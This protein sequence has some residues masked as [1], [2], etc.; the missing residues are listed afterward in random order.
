[1][2]PCFFYL[3]LLYSP[4]STIVAQCTTEEVSL[5]IEF[6]TAEFGSETNWELT[7]N[8]TGEIYATSGFYGDFQTYATSVCVPTG[9]NL[10]FKVSCCIN[11]EGYYSLSIGDFVL[12]ED[13]TYQSNHLFAF[14]ALAPTGL[15]A[16]IKQIDLAKEVLTKPQQIS[17]TLQNIGLENITSFEISWQIEEGNISTY[18]VDSVNIATFE[19]YMFKH[20]NF[21]LPAKGKHFLKVWISQLN[22]TDLSITEMVLWEQVIQASKSL[23]NRTVLV[24]A[25]TNAS[26]SICALAET[27][28]A[29]TALSALPKIA[30]IFYHVPYPGPDLLYEQSKSSVDGRL[31]IYPPVGTPTIIVEGRE[32]YTPATL[33]TAQKARELQ[34]RPAFF[35]LGIKDKLIVVDS[36][37]IND[38]EVSVL[39]HI[40]VN[41][42]DSLGIFVAII[43]RELL[44]DVPPG[45]NNSVHFFFTLRDLLPSGLGFPIE[46]LQENEY[47]TIRFRYEVPNYADKNLLRTVVFIQ[48]YETKEVYQSFFNDQPLGN[49]R[50]GNTTFLGGS[51]GQ[52]TVDVFYPTCEN[53]QDGEI[54]VAATGLYPPFDYHWLDEES[55]ESKLVGI[56]GGVY[57]LVVTDSIGEKD[58]FAIT[59]PIPSTIDVNYT[60]TS[61]ID[62]LAT[63][64]I[65]IEIADSLPYTYQW[66]DGITTANRQNL[67]AGTYIVTI[68][69]AY[70]CKEIQTITVENSTSVGNT[71]ITN[72][73]PYKIWSNPID[74]SVKIIFNHMKGKYVMVEFFNMLGQ[75]VQQYKY[76]QLFSENSVHRYDLNKL[77]A[78]M[79]IV[80][81]TTKEKAFSEKLFMVK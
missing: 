33:F 23:A 68:T 51:F 46:N 32:S 10:T 19:T 14:T 53:S 74:G 54:Q 35:S 56:A 21:W 39:P 9:T 55:T 81:V 65:T 78:G 44:F 70:A 31:S 38:I 41:S 8:N 5:F 45:L 75:S 80:K 76:Q 34:Q 58:T 36:L 17:G 7:D 79:Y 59:L 64:A 3:L 57:N 60:T 6:V 66:H 27:E 4:L 18:L 62:G 24:E 69:N 49:N 63:G 42:N 20:Q 22:G 72:N 61:A 67:I 30:P 2:K 1:M 37:Q 43:E 12:V 77:D 11:N 71:S 50:I 13:S 52:L 25:F 48:N 40:T 47:K 16:T 26:C 15:A 28:M 29:I 73:P